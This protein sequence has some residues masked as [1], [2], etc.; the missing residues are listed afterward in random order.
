ML[1]RFWDATSCC[2][3]EAK[4]PLRSLAPKVLA[5][6]KKNKNDV[7][8]CMKNSRTTSMICEKLTVII[9][10]FGWI[11][12]WLIGGLGFLGL[13]RKGLLLMGT[14]IPN[15]QLTISRQETQV[16]HTLDHPPKEVRESRS[17]LCP[18]QR[19]RWQLPHCRALHPTPKCSKGVLWSKHSKQPEAEAAEW[20]KVPV[21]NLSFIF[22]L[23]K[24]SMIWSS[25]ICG[26]KCKFLMLCNFGLLNYFLVSGLLLTFVFCKSGSTPEI[27]GNWQMVIR[28]R[29]LSLWSLRM[30]LT[31]VTWMSQT[32]CFYPHF[33]LTIKRASKTGLRW[34]GL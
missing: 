26:S 13:L 8:L 31:L 29:W 2:K 6:V 1:R 11:N 34:H 32:V 19:S 10:H 5:Q 21:S 15:H 18:V 12:W 3:V 4:C 27:I 16:G 28:S 17:A 14:L 7:N 25:S 23:G 33:G 24:G 22:F 9:Y 30:M 20:L